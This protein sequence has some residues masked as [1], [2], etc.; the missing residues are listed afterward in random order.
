MVISHYVRRGVVAAAAVMVLAAAQSGWAQPA[1][2]PEQ[3][4]KEVQALGWQRGPTTGQIGSVATINVPEGLAFLD[5]PN[6]RRLLELT[7]NPPRDNRYTLATPD[8][9]WFAI[10]FFEDSGYIKDDEKLDTDALLKALQEADKRS[11]SER[12]R[13]GIPG[14]HTAGWHVPPHYDGATKRLEWGLQ[15]RGDDG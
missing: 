7:Q 3:A 4:W 15:L 9:T 14:L 11:N 10:F 1:R 13:L 5:G 8:L 6:T 12:K 2:D